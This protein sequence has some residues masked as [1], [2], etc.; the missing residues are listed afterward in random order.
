M[1]KRTIILTGGHLSPALAVIPALKAKGYEIIFVGRKSA[2]SHQKDT[3][4]E[5]RLLSQDQRVRFEPI[6]TGRF[7]KGAVVTWPREIRRLWQG[8]I[9]VR[10]LFNESKPALVLTFGGYLAVPVC[11]VAAWRRIPIYLHEQT[12]APGRAN[13]LLAHFAHQVGVAL[14]E[15]LP[16][17]PAA[18]TK[19]TGI[20]LRPELTQP[21]PAPAW[22]KSTLPCLLI[23]GGSSGAHSLNQ[24]MRPLIPELAKQFAIV[25]QTGDNEYHDY[26]QAS[27]KVITNYFPRQ[28]L[29]PTE[30]AYLL[31]QASLLISRSGANTFFEIVYFK[32]P[33]LLLPLAIAANNEQLQQALILEQAEVAQIIRHQSG[34]ELY[35][36]INSWYQQRHQVRVR[37]KKLDEYAKLVVNAKDLLAKFGL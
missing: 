31:H 33:A 4:L 6:V 12:A 22:L 11:I 16:Y 30:S 18:K 24:L 14:P 37:F 3:S 9:R 1:S 17:F 35:Q 8:L 23:I 28:Y 26:E 36:L 5:Y 29:S 7:T 21:T 32:K 34:S 2:F 13:R 25:H 10:Q 20:A 15:A 19:L 27:Q